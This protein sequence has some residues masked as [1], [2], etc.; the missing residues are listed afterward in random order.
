MLSYFVF[1]YILGDDVPRMSTVL[2]F[3]NYR[4]QQYLATVH[5]IG[6]LEL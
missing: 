2:A 6:H 5:T 4:D 1:P 3:M